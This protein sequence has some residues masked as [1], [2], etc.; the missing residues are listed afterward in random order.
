MPNYKECRLCTSKYIPQRD[1]R[2]C[3]ECEKDIIRAVSMPVGE[4]VILDAKKVE[5]L[6]KTAEIITKIITDEIKPIEIIAKDELPEAKYT[7]PIKSSED[8]R[9]A[10]D[11][12]AVVSDKIPPIP[13]PVIPIEKVEEVLEEL[14]KEGT[15]EKVE[16]KPKEIIVEPT[17]EPESE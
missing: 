17:G 15:L 2:I 8:A 11:V 9:Y 7:E 16:E 3:S 5:T 14:V 6:E 12:V 13:V 1:E 10:T 4:P